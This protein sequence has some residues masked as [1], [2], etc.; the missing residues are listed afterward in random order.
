[1]KR[2]ILF[3]FT[4]IIAAAA[5]AQTPTVSTAFAIL[6]EAAG[7]NVF[8]DLDEDT[9]NP[10]FSGTPVSIYQGE[11]LYL[12]GEAIT[13]R[14]NCDSAEAAVDQVTM[15][16]SVNGGTTNSI[17]LPHFSYSGSDKWQEGT[18]TGMVDIAQGL[19]TGT[20]SLSL[21]FVAVDINFCH[22]G[23]IPARFPTSGAFS[24]S[25]E[26]VGAPRDVVAADD[27]AQRGYFGGWTNLSDGG[28]GFGPWTNM[29]FTEDGAA[30]FYLN[31]ALTSPIAS[32]AKAWGLYAN[33]SGSGG[34]QIQIAAA[35]RQLDQP[36][37]VGQTLVIDFQHG[38]IQS[39]SLSQNSLPRTGGWVGFA[40]RENM[41]ALFG[42][43]DP[44][45][46]FGTFQNA[47]VAVGFKGGDTEYRAYD[48]N[49]TLGYYTGLGFTTNG[50]R[51]ELTFTTTNNFTVKLTD[52]GTGSNTTAYGVTVGGPPDVLAIYNRNAEEA[53]ALFNDIYILDGVNEGRAAAD[54]AAD[55]AYLGG[56]T[57]N[58]SGG[59]GFNSWLL[60]AITN[61]GSAGTFLA[62]NPPNADLNAIASLGRAW[63]AYANDFP[64]GG[65][66]AVTAY[67]YFAG[68]DMTSGQAFGAAIEHGGISA[69]NGSLEIMMLGTPTFVNQQGEIMAFRFAGGGSAYSMFDNLGSFVTRVPWTDGGLRFHLNILRS[70]APVCYAL[71][72]D[73]RG[74]DSKVYR[75]CGELE[76]VPLAVRFKAVDIEEDDIF[77]NH[78]YLT[79]VGAVPQVAVTSL[80]IDGVASVGIQT[81]TGWL[82]SLEARTNMVLGDWQTV[83][84]QTNVPGTGGTVT[85]TGGTATEQGFY[86]VDARTNAP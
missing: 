64:G 33:E 40:L 27:A 20:Y 66:Q 28:C 12:G 68:G 78:L 84:G 57:N 60:S 63:G 74:V 50:V 16:Y 17:N 19:G 80:A 4:L 31:N 9:S 37:E 54:N 52:L 58:S 85:L 42:D 71:T 22:G 34:D 76:D 18:A 45:S 35:F 86:R 36:L 2:S 49:N 39:G 25:F 5:Q 30:G 62:T 6:R 24:A 79:L 72:V 82:Y 21:Y 75:I 1:M 43:P 15:Y 46:A 69:V 23:P 44:F 83:P 56:W 53:D 48:L 73:T 13:P 41:P 10:D 47:M 32:R 77:L 3:V 59:Y 65:V 26:V 11:S 51:V 38:N 61:G 81:L 67:R 7:A 14:Y 8:F 55:A 70:T 29:T